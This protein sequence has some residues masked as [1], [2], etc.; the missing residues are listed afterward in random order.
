M[1]D[2]RLQNVPENL[3]QV[4]WAQIHLDEARKSPDSSGIVKG[5]DK[6]F[7]A[8]IIDNVLYIKSSLKRGEVFDGTYYADPNA[9]PAPFAFSP[10]V[11]DDLSSIIPKFHSP[12]L[13]DARP[14]PFST[15]AP[16]DKEAGYTVLASDNAIKKSFFFRTT[17]IKYPT[18]TITGQ[19]DV[20][21]DQ[22]IIPFILI[23]RSSLKGE[24]SDEYGGGV[25]LV[26][27]QE[28]DIPK[29][30]T[31]TMSLAEEFI[32]N[33][34]KLQGIEVTMPSNKLWSADII[35]DS[36]VTDIGSIPIE[37]AILCRDSSP[38]LSQDEI[39]NFKLT[40]LK[41]RKEGVIRGK[42]R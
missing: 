9:R 20:F 4:S 30:Y 1:I 40:N 38:Y 18:I 12:E 2:I 17:F 31:I 15:E 19:F 41:Y 13:G 21:S 33:N 16:A 14:I 26:E 39:R 35:K 5:K 37:G 23:V 24:V 8:H 29:T 3:E 34:A 10:W 28:S 25:V 27:G 36:Y 6:N 11:I 32:I 22:E 7:E 42:L